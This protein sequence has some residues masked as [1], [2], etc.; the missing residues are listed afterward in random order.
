[1][2]VEQASIRSRLTL[3]PTWCPVG[4]KWTSRKQGSQQYLGQHRNLGPCSPISMKHWHP[5]SPTFRDSSRPQRGCWHQRSFPCQLQNLERS[6][7]P[8]G[9]LACRRG[10][11]E[12]Q[13]RSST[14]KR[15]KMGSMKPRVRGGSSRLLKERR[16]VASARLIDPSLEQS[17]RSLEG[18]PG[19]RCR[20]PGKCKLE[21]SFF[22]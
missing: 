13:F 15:C 16:L 12:R 19:F 7:Q 11:A 4:Q 9:R 21:R 6:S 17:Q 18:R 20:I 8:C 14:R 1:M 2:A 3:A 22:G 5:C 10:K